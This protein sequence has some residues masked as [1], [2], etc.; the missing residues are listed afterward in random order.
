MYGD[1]AAWIYS[2]QI[3]KITLD[4][5]LEVGYLKNMVD[6][7]ETLMTLESIRRSSVVADRI[8]AL[9]FTSL[10]QKVHGFVCPNFDDFDDMAEFNSRLN[11]LRE[12]TKLGV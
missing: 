7:K 11:N 12:S 9:E 2:N 1:P 4:L 6:Q 8:A 5:F 10:F 3:L